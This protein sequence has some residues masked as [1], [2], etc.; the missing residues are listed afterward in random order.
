VVFKETQTRNAWQ[1]LAYSAL[2][3]EVLPLVNTYQKHLLVAT[4]PSSPTQVTYRKS[5][6]KNFQLRLY[7]FLWFKLWGH[8]STSHQISTRYTEMIAN[9]YSVIKIAIFISVS[10]RQSAEWTSNSVNSSPRLLEGSLP[11]LYTIYPDYCHL[12]FWKRLHDQQIRCRTPEQRVKVI[13]GDVC[14]LPP[15]LT[16]RPPN[17]CQD[18][19]SHPYAYQTC[20]VG[21][22][23]SRIFWDVWCD[24]PIFAASPQNLASLTV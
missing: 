7:S 11:K 2:S 10:E 5:L 13:P 22:D 4:V 19:H 16:G 6:Q 21:K 1:S 23:R 14:I 9:Y 20:K 12:I 24:I 15:N 3:A 17:E 18:N 8:W